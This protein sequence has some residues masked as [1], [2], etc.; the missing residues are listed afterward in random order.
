MKKWV[1]A[2]FTIVAMLLLMSCSES[3]SK[4]VEE[5]DFSAV[6]SSMTEAAE[7]LPDM[8]IMDS[9]NEDG[10]ESFEYLFDIEYDKIEQYYF[11]Y[12]STG[13][14]EEIALIKL[15][16]EKDAEDMK[17]A[18]E[19]HRQKRLSLLQTYSPEQVQMTEDAVVVSEG[20]YVC[21]IICENTSDVK[22]VFE[23]YFTD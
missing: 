8:S 22:K 9:E 7:N 11:T 10:K 13:M 12:S 18:I 3:G 19:E 17:A 15:K 16:D 2:I 21:L 1:L 14:A 6:K 20:K 4:D 5:I 23:D